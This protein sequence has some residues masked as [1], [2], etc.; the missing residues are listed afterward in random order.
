MLLEVETE[1]FFFFCGGLSVMLNIGAVP[2]SD[3]LLGAMMNLTC[4]FTKS[5]SPLS[6]FS[7]LL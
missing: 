1:P 4:Q 2:M 7:L 5:Q 3:F 6:L